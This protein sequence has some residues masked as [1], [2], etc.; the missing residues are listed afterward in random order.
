MLLYLQTP[1][2]RYSITVIRGHERATMHARIAR[3][4]DRLVAQLVGQCSIEHNNLV[5]CR[6]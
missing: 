4:G 1:T 3:A 2:M 5:P 6:L